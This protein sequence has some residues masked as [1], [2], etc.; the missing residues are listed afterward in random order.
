MYQKLT[1]LISIV[2]LFGL[3]AGAS[4][5]EVEIPWPDC[6]IITDLVVVDSFRVEGCIIVESTG[7]LIATGDGD[8]STIDGDGGDG[9]GGNQYARL[10]INGGQVFVHSRFNIG[11]DHD[12]RL[13]I[14]D[15]G[16]FWQGCCG[17]DWGDG[18]KFPD[19]DGG[20]HY[21]TINDG[22]LDIER[23]ETR[24]ERH[25]KLELGCPS[26]AR[27]RNASAGESRE[28][29]QYWI[30]SGDA[31]CLGGCAGP[32]VEWEDSQVDAYCF[33]LPCHAWGEEPE[34]GS[35]AICP[36]VCL[37]W[38]PGGCGMGEHPGDKH[39]VFF[40]EDCGDVYVAEIG[41]PEYKGFKPVGL[42]E[43][44]P[45]GLELWTTYCWRVDEKPFGQP[46]VRGPLWTF[47][48]GCEIIP[49]DIN[50]D[51]IVDGRDWAMLADDWATEAFFPDDF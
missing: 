44:C 5:E 30:D 10:I 50:L 49:G 28:I 17:N 14:N 35:S 39:Y 47:T 29:P 1:L 7:V 12:G 37:T 33:V 11:Q 23:F 3:A 32:I 15:G 9:P 18:F 25:A 41:D 4:A 38:E 34:D 36:D 51:C 19:D 22:T 42:E 26:L 2:S 46:T 45:P 40:G 8:R 27:Q 16:S 48:T 31:C 13:I 20:E 43:Y 6:W 24:T 21:I